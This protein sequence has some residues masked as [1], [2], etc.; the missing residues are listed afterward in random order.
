[1]THSFHK[2]DLQVRRKAAAEA[3]SPLAA[4]FGSRALRAQVRCQNLPRAFLAST[5]RS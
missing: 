5:V 3:E 4:D 2:S 1:M